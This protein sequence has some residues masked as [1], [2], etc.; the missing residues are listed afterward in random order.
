MQFIDQAPPYKIK[1]LSLDKAIRAGR[2]RLTL[3]DGG[4]NAVLCFRP[5]LKE[6]TAFDR[7]INDRVDFNALPTERKLDLMI[8]E[9]LPRFFHIDKLALT[10]RD[11][12]LGLFLIDGR[13]ERRVLVDGDGV[14][15][16]QTS[17]RVPDFEMET[18]IMT[19]MAIL[20]S[21]IADFHTGKL[22][23]DAPFA[24]P[25]IGVEERSAS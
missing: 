17:D 16:V 13:V 1:S 24:A 25:A 6:A 4:G 5:E 8:E 12:W 18:D 9:L 20:R 3:G 19:L 7:E 14:R 15:A 10:G 21:L 23:L 11:S 2:A 22:D